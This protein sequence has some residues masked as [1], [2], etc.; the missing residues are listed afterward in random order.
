MDFSLFI[1]QMQDPR[2]RV[3]QRYPFD[4]MMWMI[5]LS[6]ACGY[7]SSRKMASFC[8]AQEDLF[9]RHF[10]LKHGVPSHVTFHS[11]LFHLNS[12]LFCDA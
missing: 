8:K 2:R 6:I 12:H 11:L 10:K 5:F 1:S 3:G 7:E 9:V 4:A